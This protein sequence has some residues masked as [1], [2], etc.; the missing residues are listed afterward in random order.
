MN[1]NT[2]QIAYGPDGEK[3]NN[4]K[5]RQSAYDTRDHLGLEPK[6]LVIVTRSMT[7]VGIFPCTMTV[8]NVFIEDEQHKDE[9]I[10]AAAAFCTTVTGYPPSNVF[11]SEDP[12]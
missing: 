7:E 12:L 4:V 11:F 6:T 2:D 1:H 5:K 10:A 3:I 8:E 9:I